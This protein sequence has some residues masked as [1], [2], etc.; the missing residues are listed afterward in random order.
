M[1]FSKTR[2]RDKVIIPTHL[3][4][5]SLLSLTSHSSTPTT[6]CGIN[7]YVYV[8][9][10]YIHI[11]RD[12]RG[13]HIIDTRVLYGCETSSLTLREEHRLRVFENRVLRRILGPKRDG[14]TEEWRK[15]HNEE[16]NSLYSLPNTVRVIK[17][18]RLRWAGH[19]ARMEEG[20]GVHK[21]LV[22]KPEGKRQLGRL[23]RRWEGR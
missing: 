15:L 8:Y 6:Y 12:R 5:I 1:N 14:V 2:P 13:V 19:V 10:T 17:S 18:R 23:R 4:H 22:G 9:S 16:L 7:P 20:R 3:L 21:V 11:E